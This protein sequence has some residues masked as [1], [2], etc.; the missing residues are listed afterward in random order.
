MR[1][2]VKQSVS[3]EEHVEEVKKGLAVAIRLLPSMFLMGDV[4][5]ENI[6]HLDHRSII[7]EHLTS[8]LA[9]L[10]PVIEEWKAVCL[11][12]KEHHCSEQDAIRYIEEKIDNAFAELVHEYLKPNKSIPHYCRRLIFEHGRIIRF[13]LENV[14]NDQNSNTMERLYT[15]VL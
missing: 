2:D 13:Y 15:P 7:H 11:Y 10:N 14:C 5:I 8:Y 9:L 1:K 12:K 6:Q 3:F 4:I